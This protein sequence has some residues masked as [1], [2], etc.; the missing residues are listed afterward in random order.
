MIAKEH[1]WMIFNSIIVAIARIYFWFWTNA[2]RMHVIVSMWDLKMNW[3]T[4]NRS[5]L[6]LQIQ[7]KCTC[8]HYGLFRNG[9]IVKY[10]FFSPCG[11]SIMKTK[12]NNN[13]FS[14]KMPNYFG[15]IKH[16]IV[17]LKIHFK[18]KGINYFSR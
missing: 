17:L 2:I 18:S 12:K 4:K 5:M 3:Y 13:T 1:F 7:Q 14:E 16:T 6:F 15:Q 9:I 10:F 8:Q 11:K